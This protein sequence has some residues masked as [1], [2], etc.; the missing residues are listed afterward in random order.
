MFKTLILFAVFGLSLGANAS[1]G[2]LQRFYE[3]MPGALYRGGTTEGVGRAAM[4]ESSLKALCEN[5]F[6]QA[7]FLYG[8]P[9]KPTVRCNAGEIRYSQKNWKK[10]QPILEDIYNNIQRNSGPVYVHCWYGVHASGYVS[11]VA[12]RQFCGYSA[13]RAVEYW[14][15]YIAPSLQYQEVQTLIRNFKPDSRLSLSESQKSTYCP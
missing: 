8:K 10:P 9:S 1:V 13:E 11:A 2:N 3:V 6:S 12:L 5:G 14:K 7:Y 4:K 15:S